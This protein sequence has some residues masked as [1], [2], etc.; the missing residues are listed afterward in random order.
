MKAI[1]MDDDDFNRWTSTVD[2]DRCIGCGNC[3]V[4]CE[5]EAM[6]L[7]KREEEIVPPKDARELYQEIFKKK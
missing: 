3:V 4:T 1:S 5:T 2:L 6:T 7:Q